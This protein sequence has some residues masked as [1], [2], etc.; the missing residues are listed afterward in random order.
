MY[1]R[2]TSRCDIGQA[3]CRP[4]HSSHLTAW[5]C[6]RYVPAARRRVISP[7]AAAGNRGNA[8]P[9]QGGSPWLLLVLRAGSRKDVIPLIADRRIVMEVLDGE[10]AAIVEDVEMAVGLG[11]D[12]A[13]EIRPGFGLER[14]GAIEAPPTEIPDAGF[15][16]AG[17][18]FLLENVRQGIH[19]VLPRHL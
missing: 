18:V 7:T 14:F 2:T 8:G 17:P 16:V 4:C 9:G 10:P 13:Q 1:E 19:R 6:L 12:L 15:P 3:T 5:Y 11:K